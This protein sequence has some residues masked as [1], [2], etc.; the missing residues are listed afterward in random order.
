M[1]GA[2][3]QSRLPEPG[4]GGSGRARPWIPSRLCKESENPNMKASRLVTRDVR[5][6][7]MHQSWRA[8]DQIKV[9]EWHRRLPCRSGPL[10]SD[11][12]P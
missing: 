12:M 8:A 11:G 7:G 10:R 4:I 1:A 9:L 3:D 2:L 6:F 5:T